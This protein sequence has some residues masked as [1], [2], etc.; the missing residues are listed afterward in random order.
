MDGK[1]KA[2]VAALRAMRLT[3]PATAATPQTKIRVH[4][5]RSRRTGRFAP[6]TTRPTEGDGPEVGCS[7]LPAM[8]GIAGITGWTMAI[9]VAAAE[10]P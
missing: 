4:A 9:H 8:P 6:R 10:L 5:R 2:V 3:S 7:G 1:G